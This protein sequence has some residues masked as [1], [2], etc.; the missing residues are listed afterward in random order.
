MSRC[1]VAFTILFGVSCGVVGPLGTFTTMGFGVRLFLWGASAGLALILGGLLSEIVATV[2]PQATRIKHGIWV[3]L[4]FCVAFPPLL[5]WAAH[6][7]IFP[8]DAPMLGFFK[9]YL[10]IIS[11]A[12]L[13]GLMLLLIEPKTVDAALPRLYA[14]L[15]V[16]GTARVCRLSVSDHYTE[17]YMTD[18]GCHRLL[19]RFSDAV[20]EMDNVDG[21]CSHRSHWV[22]RASVV[23]GTRRG[24]REFIALEDGTEVPV[25]KT[26]RQS[27][28]DAGFL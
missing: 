6:V 17:A 4:G 8:A 3:A 10:F 15:P 13:F 5:A 14:R 12:V 21:F 18:G 25:G 24:T 23:S 26:Y 22:T 7:Q 28:V 11:F 2:N 16:T 1:N 19:M 20:N 27:V 9:I